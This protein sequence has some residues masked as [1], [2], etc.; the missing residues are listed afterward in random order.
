MKHVFYMGYRYQGANTLQL[1]SAATVE[2][3][4]A[5]VA[6]SLCD[7]LPVEGLVEHR[8]IDSLESVATMAITCFVVDELP[9]T[10]AGWQQCFHTMTEAKAAAAPFLLSLHTHVQIGVDHTEY[11]TDAAVGSMCDLLVLGAEKSIERI[12]S[13]CAGEGF[14]SWKLTRRERRRHSALIPR[15]DGCERMVGQNAA[16]FVKNPNQR[17]CVTSVNCCNRMNG[18]D[19]KVPTPTAPHPPA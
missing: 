17:Q 7:T 6:G 19:A 9:N 4:T 8:G 5:A 2:F 13:Q 18:T 14:L 11:F 12:T 15:N 16:G 3:F 10:D 1:V